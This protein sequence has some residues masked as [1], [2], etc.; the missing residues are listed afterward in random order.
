MSTSE[1]VGLVVA[2]G[3]V[4]GLAG[5]MLVALI[6]TRITKVRD[7]RARRIDAYARWLAARLAVSRACVSFVAAF[8]SLRRE[9]R[10]STFFSLRADE[11]QRARAQWSTA[12]QEL[13]ASEAVLIAWSIHDDIGDRLAGFER[14]AAH[15]LREA[16]NGSDEEADALSQR[17]RTVDRSATEFVREEVVGLGSTLR[18]IA[19]ME[20]VRSEIDYIV[21]AS[22]PPTRRR[23]RRSQ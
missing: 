21:S 15:T 13:D 5:S 2:A 20:R 18:W 11:A 7:R 17:L 1:V 4:G 12:M 19:V 14:V 16:I 22:P 8:R 3:L 23:N 6:V 9:P 10:D